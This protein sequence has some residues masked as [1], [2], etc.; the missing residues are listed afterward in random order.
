MTNPL[1]G[2]RRWGLR[3][4]GLR[5]GALPRRRLRVSDGEQFIVRASS[6]GGG[7]LHWYRFKSQIW[8]QVVP[9]VVFAAGVGTLMSFRGGLYAA[10]GVLLDAIAAWLLVAGIRAGIGVGTEGVT[11]RSTL[12]PSRHVP[13]TA[14]TGFKDIRPARR[15]RAGTHAVAVICS[16]RN[17]LTTSA[18]WYQRWTDKTGIKPV[19]G[20]IRALESERAA[21]SR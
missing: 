19:Y 15:A 3:R 18:C 10:A 1:R 20:M 8:S 12:G 16:D 5:R 9:G 17:P 11:V 14:V 6:F 13:W 2:L 7:R 4:W 21:L